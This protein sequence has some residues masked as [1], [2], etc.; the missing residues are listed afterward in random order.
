MCL[1][2]VQILKEKKKKTDDVPK[3]VT[4]EQNGTAV[5]ADQ[6]TLRRKKREHVMTTR[7]DVTR[8]AVRGKKKSGNTSSNLSTKK[9]SKSSDVDMAST[10]TSRKRIGNRS[11]SRSSNY[12]KKAHVDEEVKVNA[13]RRV[14]RSSSR[15]SNADIERAST[16]T[17]SSIKS[18]EV[19]KKSGGSRTTKSR[20]EA[21]LQMSSREHPDE[22][23]LPP[24]AISTPTHTISE[25]TFH[26]PD[27]SVIHGASPKRRVLRASKR[28]IETITEDD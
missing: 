23:V 11:Q 28:K 10:S 21:S 15:V 9:S 7:K 6:T 17:N 8:N 4:S 19:E 1:P 22:S 26:L 14:T 2:T 25:L 24:R 3:E 18:G 16:S 27:V 13:S 20:K 12:D 5:A